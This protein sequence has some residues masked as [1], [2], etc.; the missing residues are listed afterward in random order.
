[1]SK[2]ANKNGMDEG[3]RVKTISRRN[4][5]FLILLAALGLFLRSAG[6]YRGLD[7]GTV[8]HPDSPKQVMALDQYLQGKYVWYV[9]NPFYDGYPYFLNHVDEWLIRPAIKLADGWRTH[10]TG[11]PIE[12][13]SPDRQALFYWGRTLRLL[14]GL[15]V[16]IL[17]HR[18]TWRLTGSRRAS[19]L[20]MLFAASAP[21]SITVSHAV[22][23]DIAVDLFL[24]TSAWMLGSTVERK[25]RVRHLFTALSGVGLAFAFAG[26][27]QGLLGA[28]FIGLFLLLRD[29]MGT[30]RW[31]PFLRDAGLV[32]LGFAVG[33]AIAL[34]GLWVDFDRTVR[35][36]GKNFIFIK[37]Y[38]VDSAFLERPWHERTMM[39][40]TSNVGHILVSAGWSL[41]L[42][43]F[44]G[45][46]AA[47]L[48]SLKHG[49]ETSPR[50][51]W[52]L[53]LAAFPFLAGGIALM[54]K[55]AVQPFH[56]SFV[57]PFLSIAAAYG[58]VWLW[59]A[60][61]R[62]RWLGVVLLIMV[63]LD[64]YGTLRKELFF[65]TR[66]DT[67]ALA[68]EMRE[69]FTYES[70]QP[71]YRHR[72]VKRLRLEY[73]SPA[74]F[75]NSP[76]DVKVSDGAYWLAWGRAPVPTISLPGLQDW[77]FLNGPLLP[78]NDRMLSIEPDRARKVHLVFTELP[79][80]FRIGL[81]SGYR[82]V[83]AAVSLGGRRREIRMRPHSFQVVEFPE[84]PAFSRVSRQKGEPPIYMTPMTVHPRLGSLT[85]EVITTEEGA[86]WFELFSGALTD[87]ARLPE[88]LDDPSMTFEPFDDM[89]Y[90]GEGASARIVPRGRKTVL[91]RDV[92]LA[93]GRYR[94]RMTVE[95]MAGTSRMR[96]FAAAPFQS[97]WWT[98]EVDVPERRTVT[99]DLRL[100]KSF[101]PY[102]NT[103]GIEVPAGRV[104]VVDWRLDPEAASIV[105]DLREWRAN[106]PRPEW[107]STDAA[108][109]YRTP[110]DD[111]S[112][113]AFGRLLSLRR[114]VMD[115]VAQQAGAWPL[116]LQGDWQ[117]FPFPFFDDY[118]V[119]IHLLD[120]DGVQAAS[121]EIPV[122]RTLVETE[123]LR[124]IEL[125]LPPGLSPGRYDVWIGLYNARTGLRA[126][127]RDAAERE[128]DDD[129]VRIGTLTVQAAAEK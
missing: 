62:A 59:N 107:A 74:V 23:G 30:F 110:P 108:P 56:F 8:Y 126:P 99:L 82:P 85:A 10:V 2:E 64:Q 7:N 57:I 40:F 63:F 9:G 92:P 123:R 58:F 73:Q 68:K 25:G 3:R 22:T 101:N 15:L 21:L 100:S 19:F 36:M 51:R 60:R 65:W 26:K 34:P 27:Y 39:A 41:T 105:A 97:P 72:V 77:V 102:L 55:P 17:V 80:T 46:M 122:Y 98:H 76:E 115:P 71:G 1:M 44:G 54:G 67:S 94:L 24:M 48:K 106:G 103:V 87:P 32:A 104:R 70:V 125:T 84:S 61:G 69:A 49:R 53:A 45:L 31:K 121:L 111:G 13:Q 114:M 112:T 96:L 37:N 117:V 6:L 20:A 118:Y 79:R 93:A 119:F 109:P 14:Y 11:R 50:T 66:Q 127:V 16:I 81:R 88:R 128:V 90:Y 116:I 38:G 78:R 120:G 124:P 91:L 28:L 29:G 4:V 12:P 86:A 83:K 43:A 47:V 18:V 42:L 33:L 113:V 35:D 129:R 75:R 5:F 95:S 52:A 89:Q